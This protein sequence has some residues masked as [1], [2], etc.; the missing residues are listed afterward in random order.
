VKKFGP[1]LPNFFVRGIKGSTGGGKANQGVGKENF[2]PN[3]L[4][5]H[6]FHKQNES[7]YLSLTQIFYSFFKKFFIKLITFKNIAWISDFKKKFKSKK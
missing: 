7:V 5:T 4:I 6:F 2:Y 1:R 3:R